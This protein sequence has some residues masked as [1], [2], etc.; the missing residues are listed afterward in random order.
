[1][2]KKKERAMPKVALLLI[3]LCSL[4][5]A[6]ATN[7]RPFND[8]ETLTVEL[9]KTNYNRLLVS[10]DRIAK[11]RFPDKTLAVEYAPDG[12]VYMDL[13]IEEPLTVFVT[14]R[15]GHN[16]SMTVEPKDSLGKT[17]QFIPKTP[18]LKARKVEQKTTHDE[19]VT[20]LIQ[21]MVTNR[22][23]EGYGV[24][25][26]STSYRPIN[27]ELSYK[28][29]KQIIGS[30]YTGEVLTVYNRSRTPLELNESLFKSKDMRAFSVSKTTIAP[31]GTETI[32]V[33]RE[34]EHA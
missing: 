8:N 11:V 27:K 16:F 26:L 12:S 7:Q 9:S 3:L 28:L 13:L 25:S 17:V 32:Y 20:Q 5:A 29:T 19:L 33:V 15:A 22:V 14:T 4:A 18:T 34:K 23:P 30:S 24:Q 1:M 2:L 21:A 31:H 6:H 10:Q